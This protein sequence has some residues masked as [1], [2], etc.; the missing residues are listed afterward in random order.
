MQETETTTN[1][2]QTPEALTDSEYSAGLRV[3]Y[4][5]VL[6]NVLLIAGKIAGG[7][8]G[9]SAALLADAAHS[10]SDFITDLG[11][12]V[13]L[14]FLAKPADSTHAYG[15]GRV[16]TAISFIMGA[17][18][19]LTGMGMLYTGGT[20]IVKAFHGT[21]PRSPGMIALVVGI[22]SILVKE[23]MYRYTRIVARY[24]GSKTLEAN[25][26]HHR[27]DAMSSVGVVIGVGG[28][29]MLGSRW[30]V[31]DP[32]AAVFVSVL[33]V[34]VG[35]RIVW[36]A[37]DELSDRALCSEDRDAVMSAITGVSGVLG[38]HH[39]RTRSL[40][41]SVSVDAHILV[42]HSLTVRD[43]HIIA[44][45]VEHRV[46]DALVNAAFVTIHVEPKDY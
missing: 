8:L 15:H 24:T 40:G 6:V 22:V 45:E 20:G 19:L 23:G 32:V 12:L 38:C 7:I 10:L 30:T 4:T 13:G 34:H 33:V 9:G 28:A 36:R 46:R 25:A 21:Y 37:F 41:R 17:A 18:I 31:L 35:W 39:V 27:S 42:D 26:W 44:T 5:G 11:V 14:R 29:I 3:T 1:A 16:E 43:G 2:A